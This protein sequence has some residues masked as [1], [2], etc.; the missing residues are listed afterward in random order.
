MIEKK[1]TQY[2]A[3]LKK[4]LYIFNFFL[5]MTMFPGKQQKK[6]AELIVAIN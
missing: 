5:F 2:G 1:N 3:K 4:D 6:Q